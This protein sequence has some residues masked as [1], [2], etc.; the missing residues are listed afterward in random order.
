MF[1]KKKDENLN[2][3]KQALEHAENTLNHGLTGG[4]TKA[5]MGKGFV[6]KMNATIN[7][8]KQVMNEVEQEQML[9][10]TGAEAMAEV[11]TIQ[12]TGAMV[13]MN[14]M[15]VLT[16]KVTPA[17]GSPAF[18]TTGQA[19]V[20]MVA[21]PRVGDKIKIKYNPTNPMQFAIVP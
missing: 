15:V 20:S 9:A 8:G 5:F 17:D 7:Q 11:V 10:Q 2:D 19:V 6:D 16:L 21:I 12:T 1:G 3:P 18:G 14:P 13:N 4:L